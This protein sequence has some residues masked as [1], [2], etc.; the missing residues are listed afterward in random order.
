MEMLGVMFFGMSITRFFQGLIKPSLEMVG[1]FSLLN[2]VL[3]VI[4]LPIGLLFLGWIMALFNWYQKLDPWAKT[5]INGFALFM[6]AVGGLLF[7]LGQLGLGIGS[8]ILFLALF[9]GKS[10]MAANALLGFGNIL[11]WLKLHW[12]SF[13]GTCLAWIAIAGGVIL[14]IGLLAKNW[15][16]FVKGLK[17]AGDLI[18]KY[19]LHPLD[20]IVAVANHLAAI[21]GI[22][23]F[24]KAFFSPIME[25][26]GAE[27]YVPSGVKEKVDEVTTSTGSLAEKNDEL[28][29]ILGNTGKSIDMTSLGLSGMGLETK[30]ATEEITLMA[31]NVDFSTEV[32]DTQ[33]KQMLSNITTNGKLATSNYDLA[34]SY[35]AVVSAGGPRGGTGGMYGTGGGIPLTQ[36]AFAQE[37]QQS[38]RKKLQKYSDTH[39]AG[40]VDDFIISG[41][42]VI[43]TN[44]QDTIMGFKGNGMGAGFG[45]MNFS[46][47]ITINASSNIDI[48]YLKSQLSAQW[49]DEL[50]NMARTR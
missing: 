20:L 32:L 34:K 9:S 31:T 49:R 37:V 29:K 16:D 33:V 6:L 3:G 18:F 2:T 15:D 24:F 44:P 47:N 28:A 10:T 43:K 41:G 21:G 8:L 30:Y 27:K 36:T 25:L 13:I 12:L 5:L 7:L 11:K 26:F 38:L 19:I 50:E 14:I 4:F 45:T 42:H 23:E 40:K 22:G 39:P 35:A 46:P 17:V 1:V 48:D